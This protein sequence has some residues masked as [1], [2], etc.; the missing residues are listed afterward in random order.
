M[1][2]QLEKREPFRH[3]FY[4]GFLWACGLGSVPP[5]DRL[6]LLESEG[7]IFCGEVASTAAFTR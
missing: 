5:H 6:S 2:N 1:K 4:M 7:P 3:Y